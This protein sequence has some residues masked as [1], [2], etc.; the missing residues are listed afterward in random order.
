MGLKLWV[1][2]GAVQCAGLIYLF[3][4]A[5][6]H[7]NPGLYLLSLLLLFPGCLILSVLPNCVDNWPQWAGFLV[8]EVSVVC[9]NA[10]VWYWVV[11][12]KQHKIKSG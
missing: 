6:I 9:V 5:N 1:I 3:F 7:I 4:Y 2:F 11:K 12:L 10:L 8:S